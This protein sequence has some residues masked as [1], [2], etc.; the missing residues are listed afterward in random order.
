MPELI[1]V[2]NGIYREVQNPSAIEPLTAQLYENGLSFEQHSSASYL[3]LLHVQQNIESVKRK[4]K[5]ILVGSEAV[6]AFNAAGG[7]TFDNSIENVPVESIQIKENRYDRTELGRKFNLSLLI[8]PEPIFREER[9]R[10]LS[11]GIRDQAPWRAKIPLGKIV[12][13]YGRRIDDLHRFVARH[14]PSSIDLKK[15]IV[16]HETKSINLDYI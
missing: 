12:L 9:R 14:Q 13:G 8:H 4:D 11:V 6:G 3:R 16:D 1:C 15:G 10:F 2:I 5:I 7:Q